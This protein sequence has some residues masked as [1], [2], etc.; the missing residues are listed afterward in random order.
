MA[1]FRKSTS[2]ALKLYVEKG[3]NK[4]G[5]PAY[6]IRTF[7]SL[8]GEITDEAALDIGQSLAALQSHKAG[9]VKRVDTVELAE[10]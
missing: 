4:D 7:G 9:P 6:A 5:S 2:T 8:D 10:A 1:A 3:I